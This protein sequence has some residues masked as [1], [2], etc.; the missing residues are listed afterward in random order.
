MIPDEIILFILM[1][2]LTYVFGNRLVPQV[3]I[4]LF[5]VIE[6]LGIATGSSLTLTHGYYVLLFLC[7][8]IYAGMNMVI[9]ETEN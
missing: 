3:M 7:N 2:L 8:L 5:A 9:K 1:M 4:M 6:I